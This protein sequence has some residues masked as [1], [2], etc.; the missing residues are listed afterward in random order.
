[1]RPKNLTLVI[2]LIHSACSKMINRPTLAM[3]SNDKC[4]GPSSIG[5]TITT[6]LYA[7]SFNFVD[8]TMVKR[9]RIQKVLVGGMCF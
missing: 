1:M 8:H 6:A 4:N 7:K 5:D 2:W 9:G 3:T